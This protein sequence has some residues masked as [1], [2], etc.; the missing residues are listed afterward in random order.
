MS[1]VNKFTIDTVVLQIL[2]EEQS[3]K[4][5]QSAPLTKGP[6]LKSKEKAK[7]KSKEESM[8]KEK[9]GRKKYEHCGNFYGGECWKKA[10]KNAKEN[11]SMSLSTDKDKVKESKEKTDLSVGVA[12]ITS[13][14]MTS[15]QLFIAHQPLASSCSSFDWIVNSSA[16]TNMMCEC[17]WFMTFCPLVPP[18]PVIV[19]D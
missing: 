4:A 2:I 19:G 12:N 17:S 7:E 14:D 8:T 15:L 11:G 10:A 1:T 13:P 3:H 9:K 5:T 18:Q 6:A 16:S